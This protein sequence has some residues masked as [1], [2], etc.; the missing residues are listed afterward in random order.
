MHSEIVQ[1]ICLI[2]PKLALEVREPRHVAP[3][4]RSVSCTTVSVMTMYE[5]DHGECRGITDVEELEALLGR[6]RRPGRACRS[7]G[8]RPS[9]GRCG[10]TP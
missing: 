7:P 10:R 5:H 3:F 6:C 4:L 1:Q 8:R 9:S 2:S